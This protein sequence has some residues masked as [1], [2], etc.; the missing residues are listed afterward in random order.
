VSSSC[1]KTAEIL[2]LVSSFEVR[3]RVLL[4]L[5]AS[6]AIGV[7]ERGLS[8]FSVSSQPGWAVRWALAQT[9]VESVT[10]SLESVVSAESV[11]C[12]LSSWLCRICVWPSQ[13]GSGDTMTWW[14]TSPVDPSTDY[15][16][17]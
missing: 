12:S 15:E 5:Q 16:P 13:F 3:R 17:L 11:S 14:W 1:H 8:S 2:K 10:V 9:R 4:S 6:A 7:V